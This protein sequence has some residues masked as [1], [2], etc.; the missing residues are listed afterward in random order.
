MLFFFLMLLV[1][2]FS[3]VSFCRY[4]H[5]LP[6][7]FSFP[8]PVH[9]A[10]AGVYAGEDVISPSFLFSDGRFMTYGELVINLTTSLNEITVRSGKHGTHRLLFR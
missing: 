9:N 2:I 10:A 5:G 6:C 7:S 4:C 8:V 1:T 3:V